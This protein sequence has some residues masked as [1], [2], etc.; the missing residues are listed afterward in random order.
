MKKTTLLFLVFAG[1]FGAQNVN[2]A[3]VY[4]NGADQTLAS[5]GTLTIDFNNDGTPEYTF[6]DMG[7]GGAVQ[8]GIMFA[9][10][11]HHLTTVSTGEWDVLRG[12]NAGFTIDA[13]A[14]FFDMG[15]AYVDP[16]WATT[17]FPT[18]D[19]YIGAQFRIGTSDYFGW[20]LVN[21]N[22]NGTFI[23]KSF[24]YESTPNTAITAGA[25]GQS[26]ALSENAAVD[27]ELYPNPANSTITLSVDEPTSV[28]ITDVLGNTLETRFVSQ[29]ETLDLTSYTAGIYFV[30]SPN[31]KSTK[32]IKL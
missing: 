19:T 15:D 4:N 9:T 29:A 7:F 8:P 1:F 11:N 3:I 10:A 13:F 21:W 32:F 22:A 24:A 14:G 28:T 25:T 26:A 5:G 20:I 30:S 6:Q 2:A 27:F 23:V 17:M 31:G 12:V 18:T 16:G